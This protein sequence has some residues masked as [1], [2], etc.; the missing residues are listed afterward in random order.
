MSIISFY[1][2]SS[3]QIV[4][5][6]RSNSGFHVFGFPYSSLNSMNETNKRILLKLYFY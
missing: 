5:N 2:M 3:A 4:K 1:G 6:A